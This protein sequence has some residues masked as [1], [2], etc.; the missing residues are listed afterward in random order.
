MDYDDDLELTN[1]VLRN[2]CRLTRT[3]QRAFVTMYNREKAA[4]NP[5][6][7]TNPGFAERAASSDPAVEAA[8]ADGTEVFRRRVR[9]RVLQEAGDQITIHRC[10]S[11]NRIL[12]TLLARQC[13]WCGHDWH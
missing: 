4:K 1:Y 12:R 7:M 10:P 3:E 5:K 9:D 13:L 11:C 6:L 2:Y 8:L